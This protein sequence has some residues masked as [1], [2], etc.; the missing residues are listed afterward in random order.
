MWNINESNFRKIDLNVLIVFMA[1]MREGSATRAAERLLLGQPAVS[2]ALANLRHLF[3]DQLFV[4]TGRAMVPTAR[5]EELFAALAPSL[6]AIYETVYGRTRFNPATAERIIKLGLPDD[7]DQVLLPRLIAELTREAPGIRLA[8]RQA[9][10]RSIP[11]QLDKGEIDIAVSAKPTTLARWHH[12][13]DLFNDCFV[14]IYDPKHLPMSGPVDLHTYL[15]TPHILVSASGDF[16]GAVDSRLNQL[17]LKRS[18]MM[19]TLRFSTLPGLLGSIR[20]IA[21]VP[22]L[23]ARNF[24]RQYGLAMSPLPFD[25]PLFTV[26]L[27]RHAREASEPTLNYVADHLRTIVAEME[28]D[29]RH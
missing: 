27:L 10:W 25:S 15:A 17:Q 1:L 23:T 5:A 2:H 28:N 29:M 6:T 20:A 13:D 3:D 14:C 11:D 19:T 24:V 22:K 12:A 9:D 8:V 21:N 4:R 16:T 26:S 18:V 7:L